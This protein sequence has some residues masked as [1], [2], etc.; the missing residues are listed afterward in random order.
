MS[1][2]AH[3]TTLT[4]LM[5]RLEALEANT[6]SQRTVVGAFTRALDLGEWNWDMSSGRLLNVEMTAQV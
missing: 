1:D 3:S 6:P 5:A 2:A 4:S